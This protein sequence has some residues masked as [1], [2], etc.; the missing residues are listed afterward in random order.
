[1]KNVLHLIIVTLL[2]TQWV[3]G[4]TYFKNW[5]NQT[6]RDSLT[7]GDFYAWE[8]D[9]ATPGGSA[10]I[11]LIVD[12]NNNQ[13]YDQGDI[14]LA[15]FT[16]TDGELGTDGPGDS[17]SVADGIIYTNLGP[18][19]FAPADYL[20]E[21]Q[22]LTDQS[23]VTGHLHIA[24]RPNVNVWISGH[25]T[26][27]GITP[28][29][30]R[31]AN[32]MFEA[33]D[34]ED[35]FGIISGLTDENGD[36]TINL[37]DDAENAVFKVGFMFESQFSGY[38]PDSVSFHNIVIQNGENGPFNFTLKK[39]D[40]IL[41]G[42]VVDEQ[43]QLVTV[44]GWGTLENI[45]T[46]D[47]L[48]FAI[49]EGHY[50]TAV[51]FAPDDS[52]NVQFRLHFWS[53]EL[54][55]NY[56]IPETWN[57][58]DYTFTLN[59]GDSLEKNIRV[60]QTDTVIY[61]TAQIDGQP[62]PA[63][64]EAW[65][66]SDI[67]GQSFSIFNGQ[68]LTKVFVRSGEVYNVNLSNTDYGELIV[69][70]GYY[71]EGGNWRSAWPGDTVHFNFLPAQGKISGKLSFESGDPIVGDME[72]CQVQAFVKDWNRWFNGTIVWDSLTYSISVPND[73][74]DVRFRCWNGDYL[75]FP[76]Q[77]EGVVVK[78]GEVANLN[79]TLNYAHAT[80]EVHLRNA[81][82]QT[83]FDYYLQ[84]STDGNYPNVYTTET[85]LQPDTSFYFKVCEGTWVIDAPYLGNNYVPDTDQ[86][87]VTVTEDSNHYYVEFVYHL[88][89]GIEDRVTVPEKFY[90]KQNYPNPF[91]PITT[92]EFGL[93]K[94]QMVT[95]TIYNL[96][97]QKISTL[98]KG[99]LNA[100]IHKLHWNGQKFASGIYFF[101][102]SAEHNDVIKRMVLIK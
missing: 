45:R 60:F 16:Q 79:F 71:L 90:V 93:P 19:G 94:N 42:Q 27:E 28:P 48:D 21:V 61:V 40:A 75:A 37:P 24:P 34:E 96:Q 89:T 41:Y 4:T 54:V 76:D 52:L 57:N 49:T 63:E 72:S 14:V 91:N 62:V 47:E 55:P 23:T 7:Q 83:Q 26:I 66:H 69:P 82:V 59:K 77:Y 11:K 80:I 100:G 98:F 9:V 81:H 56:L 51:P 25:L 102:I 68:L 29:D 35:S 87:T 84:I 17:S 64:F 86:Q 18:F 78:D 67:F 13:I 95:V 2:A 12:V 44:N 46:T 32:Y 99:Y 73:T 1:M 5:V 31:L 58:P 30:S 15:T 53:D 39:A 38:Q 10:S 70:S 3:F 85:N 20:F 74:F 50:K 43:G 36:F 33:S 65:A 88:D 97:G 101:R 6:Q 22:D 8:F 92:I